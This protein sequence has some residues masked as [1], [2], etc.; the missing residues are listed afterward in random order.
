MTKPHLELT[1][2]EMAF[3]TPKGAFVALENINLKIK[4]GEFVSLIG[5]SGCGK[6]TVLNIVA[7]LLQATRGGCILDGH[8]I[9][10]W[11]GTGSGIP[12]PRLDAL[13]DGLRERRTG[14]AAGIPQSHGKTGA[15][16]LGSP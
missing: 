7:G 15:S 3:D 14:G 5:H 13:A 6:S 9:N 8:E 12:E 1:G 2:V 16:G 10:S 4:K 11:P